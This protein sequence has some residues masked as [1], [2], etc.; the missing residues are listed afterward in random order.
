M[1]HPLYLNT[2]KGRARSNRLRF[3]RR[4]R[5]YSRRPLQLQLRRTPRQQTLQ[6]LQR[7]H[8]C[9]HTNTRKEGD[10]QGCKV[11]LLCAPS[12]QY[13]SPFFTTLRASAWG[14]GAR[15]PAAGPPHPP[16]TTP[17]PA[18]PPP[19]HTHTHIHTHLPLGARHA[20]P[21][22]GKRET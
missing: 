7:L 20:A 8:G 12:L 14:G 16:H 4:R 15:G 1:R 10:Q 22:V 6:V 2:E 17:P 11:C 9:R 5:R 18:A 3:G 13:P 21:C 19:T